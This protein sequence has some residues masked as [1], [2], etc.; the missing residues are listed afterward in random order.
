MEAARP[1]RTLR[2]AMRNSKEF[3]IAFGGAGVVFEHG[4]AFFGAPHPAF[5]EHTLVGIGFASEGASS[6]LLADFLT[7]DFE[8]AIEIVL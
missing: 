2:G 6:E 7:A 4:E 3:R 8:A 5:G 1:P